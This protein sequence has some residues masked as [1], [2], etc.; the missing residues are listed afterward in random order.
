MRVLWTKNAAEHLRGIHAYIAQ[1]SPLYAVR[2]IDRLT[3][4]SLR[5][6]EFPLSGRTVPEIGKNQIREVVMDSYRIIYH[7]KSDRVEILAV[8]HGAQNIRLK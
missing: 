2:V 1:G 7:I 5:I 6:G 8:I 4:A 3:R